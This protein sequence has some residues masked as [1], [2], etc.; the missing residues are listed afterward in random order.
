MDAASRPRSAC[1]WA[2]AEAQVAAMH[3]SLALEGQL[4]ASIKD[5]DFEGA[6]FSFLESA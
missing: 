3:A 1:D 4:L 2:H 5:D 6:Q